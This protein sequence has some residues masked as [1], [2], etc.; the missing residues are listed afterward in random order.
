MQY[1]FRSELIFLQRGTYLGICRLFLSSDFVVNFCEQIC[2][3]VPGTNQRSRARLIWFK[4]AALAWLWF[5]Y[6]LLYLYVGI[7]WP[8]QPQTFRDSNKK[9]CPNAV[10]TS[11]CCWTNIISTLLLLGICSLIVLLAYSR[12]VNTSH[13]WFGYYKPGHTSPHCIVLG[14]LEKV[15]KAHFLLLLISRISSHSI[16]PILLFS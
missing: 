13:R 4:R 15:R 8:Q 1:Y 11:C 10:L 16:V 9:Q 6:N 2:A 14:Y 12:A 7:N 5:F 3:R